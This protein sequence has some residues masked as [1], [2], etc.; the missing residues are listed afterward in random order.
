MTQDAIKNYTL[1]IS[2]A[3]RSEIIV[4]V[5]ELID[6]YL[7]ETIE[8][9][10][11]V[12]ADACMEA[13]RRAMKCI[14]HLINALDENYELANP[15][16]SVY[17]YMSREIGFASARLDS[18]RLNAVKAYA[19]S[20]SEAFICVAKA[21]A[22]APVMENSQ[23]VYAGLTYGKGDLNESLYDEGARRGFTV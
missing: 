12:D 22:S 19:K 23:T 15:L 13:G 5:Y 11:A 4:I 17:S 16:M 1:R 2:Q 10:V 9:A 7:D 6:K 8:A 14:S 18:V 3:N 20:L 21:D